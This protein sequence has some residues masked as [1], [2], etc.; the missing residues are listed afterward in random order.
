MISV[1]KEYKTRKEI[2]LSKVLY[3]EW[4]RTPCWS[5]GILSKGFKDMKEPAMWISEERASQIVRLA[6]KCK[7]PGCLACLRKKQG[8]HWGQEEWVKGGR[9]KDEI[10]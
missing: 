6:S 2:E 4:F 7:G 1:I 8:S 5:R 9:V 3:I 10:G